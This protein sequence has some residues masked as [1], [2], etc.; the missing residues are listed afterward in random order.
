[1]T[2]SWGKGLAIT[3]G[4]V[5]ASLLGAAIPANAA[6][7]ESASVVETHGSNLQYSDRDVVDFLVFGRGEIAENKPELLEALN[8]TP[9]PDAPSSVTDQLLAEFMEEDPTFHEDVTV[10]AQA[11]DP[12]KAEESLKAFSDVV[13]A[14]AA[15]HQVSS[16]GSMIS[17]RANGSVWAFS[18]Y[19]VSTQVAVAAAI[20]ISV[21]GVVAALAVIAY[22]RPGDDNAIVRQTY[23]S[24]WAGL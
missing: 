18:N 20:A 17:T 7:A 5:S 3:A 16:N 23:A 24:A 12:Y 10:K 14:V 9:V 21:I 6:P 1:M 2:V 8:M 19:V 22:Q 11:G 15:K 13:Q 4:L